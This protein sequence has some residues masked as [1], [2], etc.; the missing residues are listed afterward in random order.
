MPDRHRPIPRNIEASLR[1]APLPWDLRRFD[2]PSLTHDA[3]WRLPERE[4]SERMAALHSIPE[5]WAFENGS[6]A[7]LNY[8]AQQPP[9]YYWIA[10]P[11]VWLMRGRGLVAQVMA[12]RWLSVLLASLI[13]PLVYCIGREL[14]GDARPA[15]GCAA[16]VTVMPGFASAVARVGNEALAAPLYAAL[17]LAGLVLWRRPSNGTA[18]GVA[19]L[20][21]LGLLTKAY[22]LTAIPAVL[23]LLW[24]RGQLRMILAPIL[25]AGWWYVRNLLTTGTLAGLGEDVGIQKSDPWAA[26]HALPSVPW[27]RAIDAILFSHLYCLGWSWLTVRS[28]MYHVLYIAIAA[29]A[30]GL[31]RWRRK[32]GMQWVLGI[33]AFFWL[34]D[35]WHTA[36]MYAA[37]G[38]PTSLGYYLYGVVAAEATLWVAGLAVWLRRWSAVVHAPSRNPLLHR[39]DSPSGGRN[40]AL[41]AQHRGA[42]L[43]VLAAVPGGYA[44]PRRRKLP[45]GR[46]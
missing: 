3:Y 12:V 46:N 6:G 25:V 39:R 17:I 14:F 16:L 19:G 18:A 35:L 30:V 40:A 10:A 38:M 23:W 45:S 29:A 8:E 1:L 33:Y 42:F 9:I 5:A 22:F 27:A 15:L 11:V 41:F 34:G 36:L 2:P 32:P 4:R 37:R 44:D 24:R 31:W 28:W 43:D 21:S 7:F 20:L 26:L 13:V